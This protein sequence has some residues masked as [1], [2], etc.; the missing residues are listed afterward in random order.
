MN[1]HATVLSG[2]NDHHKVEAIFKALEAGM[3]RVMVE[4]CRNGCKPIGRFELTVAAYP[5]AIKVSY[6]PSNA[7]GERFS[8]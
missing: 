8:A 7:E 5:A 4:H 1:L 3:D 6:I 2:I